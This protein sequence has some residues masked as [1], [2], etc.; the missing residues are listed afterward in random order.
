MI[1][2]FVWWSGSRKKIGDWGFLF[3][4]L[5]ACCGLVVVLVV[6]VVVTDGRSGCGWYCGC[7][8]G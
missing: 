7:F 3:F 1:G 8:F 6:V 5:F 2:D 4:F